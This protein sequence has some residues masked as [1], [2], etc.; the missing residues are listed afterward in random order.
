MLLHLDSEN[1]W[2]VSLAVAILVLCV[3]G[4]YLPE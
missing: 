4:S 2:T 1:D 3:G